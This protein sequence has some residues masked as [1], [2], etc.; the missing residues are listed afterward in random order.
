LEKKKTGHGLEAI[1]FY[2]EGKWEELE[3][4][5]MADV[6]LTK[7]LFDYG[8]INKKISY[9]NENGKVDIDVNWGKYLED[10]GG[11]EMP[12]TLPF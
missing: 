1:D 6:M 3:K 2:K 12:L 7:E 11:G 5:C 8:I 9:L 4:Y 10:N